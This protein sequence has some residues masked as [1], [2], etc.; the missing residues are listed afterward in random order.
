MI[1]GFTR[2]VTGSADPIPWRLVL[3]TPPAVAA[4]TITEAK[5]QVKQDDAAGEPSPATA[6]TLALAA[7]GAG[8]CENGAHRLAVSYVTADGETAPGPLSAPI[9]V[10]DKTVNGKLAVSV[11]PTGGSAVLTIKFW[12][13]LVGTV[14]PLFAAG[15]VAN[16]VTTATINLADGSLGAQAPTT[17]TTA[18]P[19]LA[20]W[21]AAAGSICESEP[22]ADGS[23]GGTGRA[24]ITQTWKLKLDRFPNTWSPSVGGYGGERAYVG[25][26]G[27]LVA[28]VT[29]PKPPLQTITSVTY[30]D[31]NGVT[32]TW[33]PTLWTFDAPSGDTAEPGRLFPVYGE[34]YPPTRTQPGAVTVTF[35]AGYGLT[36]AA[37]PAP[38]KAGQRLLLGNWWVNREA[39][40]I[41]RG[42]ADVLPFGVDALWQAFRVL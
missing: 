5:A 30:V 11:I 33:D 27:S 26:S 41:I 42:S 7:A 13:P 10:A 15:S 21:I 6:P 40:Q 38:L 37:V 24:L 8:V 1:V 28:P 16:G 3:V 23:S 9:T 2:S 31:P 12:M 20:L 4:L 35:T 36:G 17:N 34:I 19:D 22:S 25:G 29:I 39:A 14:T 18:D 32:Q